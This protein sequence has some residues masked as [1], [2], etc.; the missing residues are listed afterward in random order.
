M[1][2]PEKRLKLDDEDEE[3]SEKSS[4]KSRGKMTR[5]NQ[6]IGTLPIEEANRLAEKVTGWNFVDLRL[7]HRCPSDMA[8]SRK[9]ISTF[10]PDDVVIQRKLCMICLQNPMDA[11]FKPHVHQNHAHASSEHIEVMRRLS[12]VRYSRFCQNGYVSKEMVLEIVPILEKVDEIL[13]FLGTIGFLVI[14]GRVKTAVNFEKKYQETDIRGVAMGKVQEILVEFGREKEKPELNFLKEVEFSEQLVKSA[15]QLDPSTQTTAFCHLCGKISNFKNFARHVQKHKNDVLPE[16]GNLQDLTEIFKRITDLRTALYYAAQP[17]SMTKIEQL[18]DGNGT[19]KFTNFLL[20]AGFVVS[21]SSGNVVKSK[22]IVVFGPESSKNREFL[23][24][25]PS[26][27]ASEVTDSDIGGRSSV[28][29][30][31]TSTCSSTASS[32]SSSR[33]ILRP[34]SSPS[35]ELFPYCILNAIPE[36]IEVEYAL[37]D[38]LEAMTDD[39]DFRLDQSQFGFLLGYTTYS[40]VVANGCKQN[41][42]SKLTLGDFR[43]AQLDE[44]SGLHYFSFNTVTQCSQNDTV[45]YLCA[46]DRIWRALEIYEVARERRVQEA[47]GLD[48]WR[49]MLEDVAPFFCSFTSPNPLQKDTNYPMSQFLRMCGICDF[50]C[51]SSAICSSAWSLVARDSKKVGHQKYAIIYFNMLR[52]KERSQ[53][54]LL[55]GPLSNHPTYRKISRV[56]VSRLSSRERGGGTV[57]KKQK[58]YTTPE[59]RGV[60][61]RP[62]AEGSEDVKLPEY[63]IEDV[64]DDRT[65]TCL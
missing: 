61:N 62:S 47:S 36:H 55:D 22:K 9:S 43:R 7:P 53:R 1:P 52:E 41:V 3:E 27:E 32:T 64:G 18:C 33:I 60:P 17:V 49:G 31:S 40:L 11:F 19:E 58:R 12:D 54:Q 39:V 57:R 30:D 42:V 15:R 14:P 46:N 6:K 29:S 35:D 10:D 50:A 25:E 8:N 16:Y 59:R 65:M 20:D 37:Y 23:L 56:T 48:L 13:N 24:R 38:I 34:T 21:G 26:F 28:T 51:R 45:E 4:R 5:S 63:R 44:Q 2:R